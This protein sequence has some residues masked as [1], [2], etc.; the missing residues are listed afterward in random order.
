MRIASLVVSMAADIS[1]LQRGFAAAV[2][3]TNR[4]VSR[5]QAGL[6]SIGLA[7]G[8]REVTQYADAWTLAT[9]RIRLYT[10]SATEAAQVQAELFRTAQDT[11]SEFETTAT[12]YTRL[13][14][15][16]RDL[17]LQSRDLLTITRGVGNALRLS[18][19]ST[20]ESVSVMRQLSQAFSSGR[21]QGDE[22]RSIVENSA[23]LG[24][25]IAKSLGV[26]IGKLRELGAEGKVLPKQVA[27]A[28]LAAAS[29]LEKDASSL[30]TTIGQAFTQFSNSLQRF[31]GETDK[32]IGGSRRLVS[33][34]NVVGNAFDNNRAAINTMIF[35]L[36]AAG[37]AGVVLK[38]IT[39]FRALAAT[40]TALAFL[41]LVP[42]IT[43]V[44]DALTL[45]SFAATGFWTAL[46][47]PIGIAI[48]GLT[49]ITALFFKSQKDAQKAREEADKFRQAMTKLSQTQV[50]IRINDAMDSL[51]ELTV[52][53][54]ALA[55]RL[56]EEIEIGRPNI[57]TVNAL[58][59]IDQQIR[60][61]T[62]RLAIMR[63]VI[64]QIAAT[65]IQ[66]AGGGATPFDFKEFIASGQR[67]L[68]FFD[69]LRDRKEST[70]GL[71]DDLVRIFETAQQKLASL[72]DPLSEEAAAIRKF[73]AEVRHNAEAMAVI[74]LEKARIQF[75]VIPEITVPPLAETETALTKSLTP[76]AAGIGAQ[77]GQTLGDAI[78]GA[79]RLREKPKLEVVTTF[80][81]PT[82]VDFRNL[83]AQ[84]ER[85]T[86]KQG[87][88]DLARL[89]DNKAFEAQA[90]TD[91]QRT[92]DQAIGTVRNFAEAITRSNLPLNVQAALLL[93]LLGIAKQLPSPVNKVADGLN[94]FVTAGR[95]VVQIASQFTNLNRN[96]LQM[97][98]SLLDAVA[99]I[100]QFN[101]AKKEKD[102]LGQISGALG[103]AGAA[104][105]FGA[106]LSEMIFG[107]ARR[108]QKELENVIREN[109]RAIAEN[110]LILKGFNDTFG[111]Q[112]VLLGK[113]DTLIGPA[114]R[115]SAAQDN[116]SAG[117]AASVA[118]IVAAQ[119]DLVA[120][121][122][123]TGFTLAEMDAIAKRFNI[124]LFDSEGRI[125]PQAFSQLQDQIRKTREALFTFENTL[126][127]VTLE[128]RLRNA[129]AGI[130]ETPE[131]IVSDTLQD[132]KKL[133]PKLFER[134][135]AE[136][137]FSDGLDQG[138]LAKI[139]ERSRQIIDDFLKGL[140]GPEDLPGFET[141]QQF[142]QF[143]LTWMDALNEMADAANEVTRALINV[144]E[145]FKIER[146]RFNAEIAEALT[147]NPNII[148]QP[149]T[150]HVPGPTTGAS[151]LPPGIVP[152]GGTIQ[153]FVVEGD[154]YVDAHEQPPERIVDAIKPVLT[155]RARTMS[156]SARAADA[157]DL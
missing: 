86:T 123:A 1:A 111:A 13:A 56:R 129:G 102:Q 50:A 7:I 54:D 126:E 151:P 146:A 69:D 103:A 28:I 77:F 19:A 63:E 31:I 43:G 14:Q 127:D 96:I 154:V 110:T 82:D 52:A 64:G 60:E 35:A 71:A 120:A 33:V 18:N 134:F 140:I 113:L 89:T 2:G 62:S 93:R 59:A 65:P 124:T 99:A 143:V 26:S 55:A 157:F 39:A 136:I 51:R 23:V 88:V 87:L 142:A 70:T 67:L 150:P 131:Q 106:A 25:V 11:R 78:V 133:A 53:K 73:I 97:V 8:I 135:F 36:G 6:A 29:Q 16:S 79:I 38:L 76:I 132:L 105:S 109:T 27:D 3:E 24:D 48:V 130:T 116:F 34:I 141:P 119:N 74:D 153:N 45:A 152:S 80:I 81:P 94:Q 17:G 112:G 37:L 10:A 30:P 144:P 147:V 148:R 32:A 68:E 118:R 49:A 83:Q 42:A 21:F 155:R 92:Y 104:V 4:M 9:G 128:R 44:R 58:S 15:G 20:A 61:T 98:G 41:S 100:R 95:G 47:G 40:Q 72:K 156:P 145:G 84:I 75:P 122:H 149:F 90:I 101:E 115:L 125:I 66:P 117:S 138:E 108:A 57:D 114:Q 107:A 22:L 121:I 137:D 12:L 91:F 46:T 85:L 139:R 5:I